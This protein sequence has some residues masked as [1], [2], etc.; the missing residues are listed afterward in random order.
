[1][2]LDCSPVRARTVIPFLEPLQF[3]LKPQHLDA[4]FLG[5]PLLFFRAPLLFFR[6]PLL[7]FRALLLFFRALLL[8]FRA[9]LLPVALHEERTH[10]HLQRRTV[11]WQV[12]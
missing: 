2:P 10:H 3:E 9:L 11:L 5:L 7:F 4:E 6:A 8:F 1:L 12:D